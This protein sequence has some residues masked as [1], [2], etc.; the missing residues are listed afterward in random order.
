MTATPSNTPAI[1]DAGI[2]SISEVIGTPI[3]ATESV[4]L[5]IDNAG[6]GTLS[7]L[8]AA[9]TYTGA[10]S[11]WLVVDNATLGGLGLVTGAQ[12]GAPFTINL[13]GNLSGATTAHI[14]FSSSQTGVAPMVL[15]FTFTPNSTSSVDGQFT[16]SPAVSAGGTYDFGTVTAGPNVSVW[17]SP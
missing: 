14:T 17:S 6:G 7:G 12:G 3:P 13:P 16:V 1:G 4:Q 8:S 9:V 5:P 15:D 2:S 10:A 11:G